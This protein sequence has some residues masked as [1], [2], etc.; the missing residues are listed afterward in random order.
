MGLRVTFG[1]TP[2]PQMRSMRIPHRLHKYPPHGEGSMRIS[3][4]LNTLPLEV[5]P[6][7]VFRFKSWPMWRQR[8][9]VL[10][11]EFVY[12]VHSNQKTSDPTF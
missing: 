12:I 2:S 9:V 3:H 5:G 8:S 1:S 4:R 6:V 10:M 7:L 11:R